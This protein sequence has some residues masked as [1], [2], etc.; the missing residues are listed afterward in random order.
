LIR[1]EHCS[2]LGIIARY[3]GIEPERLE[4]ETNAYGKPR[5]RASTLSF[6]IS[7]S[8]PYSLVGF[9]R[10]AQLGVDL[11]HSRRVSRRDALLA[12]CF[13]AGERSRIEAG[14]EDALLRHWTAKEAVVK[15]IGRGIAYGLSLIEVEENA[16]GELRLA[17]L[18]GPAGPASGWQLV[19]GR[20]G[21]DGYVAVAH[22]GPPR[23]LSC[24]IDE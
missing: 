5:I 22:D 16:L 4:L 19:G 7:H 9:A 12:R 20:V 10:N 23:A 1:R 17:Q 11:E 13:T 6:S 18:G 21:S 3:I 2:A 14:D 24:W 15:A 8:G